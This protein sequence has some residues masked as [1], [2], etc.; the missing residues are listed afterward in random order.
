[1]NVEMPRQESGHFH[2]SGVLLIKS[3]KKGI[4]DILQTVQ[5]DFKRYKN[6]VNQLKSKV[7][8]QRSLLE[9]KKSIPT[10]QVFKHRALA[11][12]LAALTEDIEEL[13][14][15]EALL[16]NQFDCVDNHSMAEVK[17]SLR[18]WTQ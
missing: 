6:V 13:K 14:S 12:R 8:E 15:K 18:K 10:I 17:S 11:Q 9:E 16:L 5:S 7:R 2:L 3:S 1:M 4:A